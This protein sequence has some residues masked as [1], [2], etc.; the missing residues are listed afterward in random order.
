MRGVPDNK[1][2]AVRPEGRRSPPHPVIRWPL[3]FAPF[4]VL[5]N[6]VRFRGTRVNKDQPS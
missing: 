4:L 5:G 1:G 2:D 6:C 3:G